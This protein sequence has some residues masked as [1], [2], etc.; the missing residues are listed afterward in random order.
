VVCFGRGLVSHGSGG[1][2][3]LEISHKGKRLNVNALEDSGNL[4]TEPISGRPVVILR[5]A[6]AKELLSPATLDAL[7]KMTVEKNNAVN[8]RIRFVLYESVS[9]SGMLGAFMPESL[10]VNGVE[11][12]GWIAVSD[13]MS[14]KKGGIGD[15]IVPSALV[16]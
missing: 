13:N 8:E 3:A 4:L 14:L 5:K 1:S 9:G 10:S 11:V 16:G 15:A 7:T 2:V 6:L 12:S